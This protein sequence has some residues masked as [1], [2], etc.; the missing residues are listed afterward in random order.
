MS[1][2]P[3]AT[4]Y[5]P[6][7]HAGPRLAAT[8]TGLAAQTV[9]IEVVI[10]DNTD[11]PKKIEAVRA[12]FP[13][14]RTVRFGCNLG[15]GKALNRAVDSGGRN[16]VVLLND[17]AVPRPNFVERLL[18]TAAESGAEMVAAVL[19]REGN[20]GIIDSA[21][22]VADETLMGFDYLSGE[23]VDRLSGAAA[24]LGPTGGGAFYSRRAFEL[25][26]GFDERIFAYYED[27]D[28]ALRLRA[29][30]VGC[31]LSPQARVV[32]AYSETLGARSDAKYAL[33]GW[34]R[35]YLARRYGIGSSPRL[36]ARAL[37]IEA[38][39]C[40]GQ[41]LRDRTASGAR[42]RIGG[43]RAARGLPQRPLP[44]TGLLK[45]SASEALRMRLRR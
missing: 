31:A 43:W 19:V 5:I 12:S 16:A 41:I 23:P 9:P 3:R 13:T 42:S 38:V 30:G 6:T 2:E 14:L 20:E 7:L 26:G 8:L 4:V 35:G 36:A 25:V 15:F 10:A 27:L 34:S 45:L 40:A 33:T 44:E 1:G 18:Q 37:A 29:A 28:L 32:H 24:P 17:D 21:G 11:S 39:V 22:V